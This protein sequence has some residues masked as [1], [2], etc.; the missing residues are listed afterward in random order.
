M[1]EV[2]RRDGRTVLLVSH[3]LAT[4]AALTHRALL[5]DSGNVVSDGPTQEVIS[6]YISKQGNAT[7]Y[8]R[9]SNLRTDTP[10]IR[11]AAVITSE[12]NGIHRFGAPL[13]V[14]LWVNH[15]RPLLKGCLAVQLINQF[16]QC[17]VYAWAYYPDVRFGAMEGESLLTCRFPS[18]RVNVGNYYLRVYLNEPPQ[19][20]IYE[21]LDG[22]C[23]FEVIRTDMTNLWGW[24]PDD[25]AYH[26]DWNWAVDSAMQG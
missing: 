20:E 24:N 21:K 6:A 9:P 17:V 11:Q 22:V 5:L 2:S 7:F 15:Q 19:G 8:V 14:K 10:H 12:A 23:Q 3:N 13:E 4:V 26:E 25:C 16:Q 1:D 18:L